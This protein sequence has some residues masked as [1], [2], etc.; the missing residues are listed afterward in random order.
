M[1][2]WGGERQIGDCLDLIEEKHRQRY[3][4][5]KKF[6]EGKSVLDAACG[7]GYGTF[8][9]SSVAQSVVGLDFSDEATE[10]AKEHYSSSNVEFG[11]IDLESEFDSSFNQKFETIVSFE[12]VEHI[13]VDVGLTCKRFLNILNPGGILVV[14]HPHMQKPKT[15]GFHKKFN[16]HGEKV[17]EEL[18]SQGHEIVESHYQ[19]NRK[20]GGYPYHIFVVKKGE[21]S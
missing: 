4:F 5:A 3:E 10:Y 19:P 14:S 8:M 1:D 9:I 20:P 21:A 17:K 16:I 11:F 18:S 12:T 7:C 13:D 6:C 2:G 15:K